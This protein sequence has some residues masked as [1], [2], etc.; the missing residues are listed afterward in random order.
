MTI[1]RIFFLLCISALCNAQ[2]AINSA[3]ESGV[4]GGTVQFSASGGTPPYVFT[5]VSPSAGS[6]NSSTGVYTAPVSITAHTAPHGCQVHPNNHI[7]NTDISGVPVDTRVNGGGTNNSVWWASFSGVFGGNPPN[8]SYELDAPINYVK[9]TDPTTPMVF[10]YGAPSDNF[11]IP[12]QGYLKSENGN[13]LYAYNV[14]GVDHHSVMEATDI[15]QLQ[16]LY[17]LFPN[18]YVVTCLTLP[19]CTSVGG[20]KINMSTLRMNAYG[21]D[22]AGLEWSPLLIKV[23]ELIAGDIKHMARVTMCTGCLDAATNQWPAQSNNGGTPNTSFWPYGTVIR[24]KSTFTWPG[25]DGSCTTT[26]CH[27]YVQRLITQLKTY[28]VVVADI[29]T[30]SAIGMMYDVPIT[31]DIQFPGFGGG[32]LIEM[33]KIVFNSTNFEVVE[34]SLLETSQSG[35]GTD[36]TWGGIKCSNAYVTPPECAIVKVTDNLGATAQKEIGLVGLAIGVPRPTE[37]FEAGTAPTQMVAWASGLNSLTYTCSLSPSG[38]DNGTVTSGCLYSPAASVAG[39]TSTTLTFTASD[40]ITTVTQELV[41]F[42]AGVGITL[43]FNEGDSTDYTDGNGHLWVGDFD[44]GTPILWESSNQLYKGVQSWTNANNAPGVYTNAGGNT[45]DVCHTIHV[46]NGVYTVTTYI[47]STEPSVNVVEDLIDANGSVVVPRFDY[48]TQAGAQYGVF[49]EAFTIT[50]SNGLLQFNE[51]P[52]GVGPTYTDAD[53]NGTLYRAFGGSQLFSYISGFT[54]T[55]NGTGVGGSVIGG[56]VTIG[57]N[58]VI[59]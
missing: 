5:I 37:V 11:N 55:Q 22:A 57:G 24:L 35:T 46:P 28:G 16:E 10:Y 15:C 51:R 17:Q 44:A 27:T 47:G 9:S 4:Q 43:Y 53:H 7:F 38:G 34:Q 33:N 25:Y 20:Q 31:S 54:I 19:N 26:L 1:M 23:S 21:A 13:A 42:P 29:G 49:S 3:A 6:V 48:F 18:T 40:G 12:A 59:H 50:V 2:L 8:T 41:I 14:P 30:T 52:L 58:V 45:N 39:K 56:N 32:A 36:I